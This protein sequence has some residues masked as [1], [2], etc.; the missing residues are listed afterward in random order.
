MTCNSADRVAI[1][2]ELHLKTAV[3]PHDIVNASHQH[4]PA[5]YNIFYRLFSLKNTQYGHL[6]RKVH[7]ELK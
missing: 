1:A 2:S 3:N 7:I 4:R 5:A 6:W